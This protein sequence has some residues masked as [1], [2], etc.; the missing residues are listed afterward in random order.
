MPSSFHRLSL[1]CL[2]LAVLS[3]GC[4]TGGEIKGHGSL[5]RSAPPPGPWVLVANLQHDATPVVRITLAVDANQQLSGEAGCNRWAG[6]WEWTGERVQLGPLAT[7]R[8]MCPP[9]VMEAEQ[10]FLAT[11]AGAGG[12][13]MTDRGL[14]LTDSGTTGL[15]LFSLESP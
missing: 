13:Q 7:T 9:A 10:R 5:H 14:L 6:N 2:L 4:T 11:L 8:K 12:W 15:L 1:P 3:F